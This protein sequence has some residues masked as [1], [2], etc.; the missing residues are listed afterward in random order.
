M[1]DVPSWRFIAVQCMGDALSRRFIAGSC[2]AR[3]F[4]AGYSATPPQPGVLTPEIRRSAARG[5]ADGSGEAG[6]A[7]SC[8]PTVAESQERAAPASQRPWRHRRA[9]RCFADKRGDSGAARSCLP[10][11]AESAARATPIYFFP[12]LFFIYKEMLTFVPKIERR[13]IALFCL[14]RKYVKKWL[15]LNQLMLGT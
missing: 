3:H 14:T 15:I 4:N 9:P 1:G 6:A 11:I 13:A 5:F 7:R 12:I 10:T 8:L 2:L